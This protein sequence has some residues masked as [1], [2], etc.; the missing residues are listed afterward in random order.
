M[1]KNLTIAI[2]KDL[3]R[4]AK[5]LAAQRGTS[6]SQLL[7]DELQRLVD[8]DAAYARASDAALAEI[9]RGLRLG[10]ATVSRDALHER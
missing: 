4:K 3:I 6:H 8:N 5:L 10:G 2:E 7:A 9:D 1:R